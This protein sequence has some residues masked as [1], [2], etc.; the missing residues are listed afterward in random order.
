MVAVPGL[1]L[2]VQDGG[3]GIVDL[4]SAEYSAKI[5][6]CS[7]GTVNTVYAFSTPGAVRS[8]L[9]YGP[10]AEACIYHIRASGKPVYAVRATGGSAGVASAV[11]HVGSGPTVTVGAGTPRDSYAIIIEVTGGGILGAGTMRYSLDG[12]DTY[13]PDIVIPAGGSYV[14]GNTGLTMTFAAGTYV[15]GDTYSVTCTEPRATLGNLGDAWDALHADRT[16]VWRFVHVVGGGAD[17]S[18]SAAIAAQMSTD[19]DA[20]ALDRRYVH[21]I[22]E[23]A[24]V[25]TALLIAGFVSTTSK[26]VGVALGYCELRQADR[27]VMRRSAAWPYAAR[28]AQV[29]VSIDPASLKGDEVPDPALPGVVSITVDSALDASANNANFVTLRTHLGL[30]G[31][32]VTNGLTLAPPGSDYQLVQYREIMDLACSTAA[33]RLLSYLS[34]RLMVDATTGL[35]LARAANAIDADV[36][37]AL[38]AALTQP[39]HAASASFAVDRSANVLSTQALTGEVRVTPPGYAK[40]ITVTLTLVNPALTEA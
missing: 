20:A 7:S 19:L 33:G 34:S 40:T 28:K 32:Y 6:T 31:F 24:D 21:A 38:R 35:L 30:P 29:P 12:G 18:A 23:A 37:S 16:K 13:T 2:T 4:S 25:S 17:A 27:A 22:C 36:S 10:L 14:L 15:D 9:G 3:L 11:T 26:R 8:T 39:G 5:G 1:S